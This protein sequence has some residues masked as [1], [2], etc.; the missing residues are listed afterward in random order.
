MLKTWVP[1]CA[2]VFFMGVIEYIVRRK[3]YFSEL[4]MSFDELRQEMRE[5]EGDPH[6]KVAQQQLHQAL[7]YEEL[8]ARVRASKVLIVERR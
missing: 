2:L 3:K 6:I 1:L 7:A 8:V 5:E 4:S